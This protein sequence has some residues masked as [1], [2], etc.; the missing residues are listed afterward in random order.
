MKLEHKQFGSYEIVD[1]KQRHVEAFT[2][3][4]GDIKDVK[5]MAYRRL[6]IEAAIKAGWFVTPPDGDMQEE[7]P[8]FVGW[9]GDAIAK[10]FAEVIE[11]PP[12]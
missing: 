12:S 3:N 6:V 8:G 10:H 5:I 2:E 9:L 1:L 7:S 11:I 4:L